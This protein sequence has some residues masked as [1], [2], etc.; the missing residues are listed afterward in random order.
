MINVNIDENTL[1][2]LLLD[3]LK[4]LTDDLDTLELFEEYYKTL[5]SNEG[6]EGSTLNIDLIVD[7]DYINYLCVV[8]KDELSDYDINI[9][10]G[11][12]TDKIRAYS[13]YSEKYLVETY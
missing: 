1:L 7:N 5:I 4:T 11:R 6:F 13:R 8:D 3:R 2:N 9:D 12:N 10:E